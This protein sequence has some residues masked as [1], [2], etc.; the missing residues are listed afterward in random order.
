[1]KKLF[2][3]LAIVVLLTM[4]VVPVASAAPPAW[5]GDCGGDHHCVQYG[6]TLFSIG[7]AYGVN[8]YQI[9]EVNGLGNPNRIYAGQVL[10]IPAG[11]GYG[12]PQPSYPSYGHGQQGYYPSHYGHSGY[13]YNYGYHYSSYGYNYSG[14]YYQGHY[15]QNNRYSY[16]CGYYHNCY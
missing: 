4:F 8:P 5:G 9:A 7:R 2:S 11:Y 10:Y 12:H 15:P 16:T 3:I 6:E 14:Y 1:M 13:G